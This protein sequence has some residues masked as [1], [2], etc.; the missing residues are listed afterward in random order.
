M[1][2]TKL[3]NIFRNIHHYEISEILMNFLHRHPAMVI[4]FLLL[5]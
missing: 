4:I 1:Y 3:V 2:G 5:P